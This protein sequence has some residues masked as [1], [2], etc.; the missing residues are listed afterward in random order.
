M[1]V[2]DGAVIGILLGLLSRTTLASSRNRKSGIPAILKLYEKLRKERTTI[3]VQSANEA[4]VFYHVEDGPE[5]EA[6]D[7]DLRKI[8]W[9]D[10]TRQCKWNWGDTEKI[11]DL[12]GFD[13][14]ADTKKKFWAWAE[15][16]G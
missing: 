9:R 8:D 11:K 7:A 5:Q 14:I 1:A 3:N 6:R 10:H 2:E 12:L 16:E 15:A 4:K 13:T